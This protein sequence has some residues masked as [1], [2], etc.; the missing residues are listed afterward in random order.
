VTPTDVKPSSRLLRAAVAERRDIER[1]RAK[2]LE[3]RE[4]VL[5]QLAKIDDSMGLLDERE[6][7]LARLAPT[8]EREPAAAPQRA[9][10][11]STPTVTSALPSNGGD[12]EVH[13]ENGWHGGPPSRSD[14]GAPLRGPAI[15]ETAVSLLLARGGVEAIHY[16]E[17]FGLLAAD[18]YEV[19]GKDPLAVF[20]TQISRSPVVTKATQSG[21]YALDREAPT[22][23]R[24]HLARLHTQMREV[25]AGGTATTDL[26]EVRARREDLMSA[27][28]QTERA[29]EE[30]ERVLRADADPPRARSGAG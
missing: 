12:R 10:T 9:G 27:V 25:T 8:P 28:S 29:L 19:A 14:R 7:L 3:A 2:L 4:A 21:V 20:L 22:R 15:R 13:D 26:A 17:W 16:R 5:A 1:Q 24:L 30:A 6:L 23:L 11:M 18:G